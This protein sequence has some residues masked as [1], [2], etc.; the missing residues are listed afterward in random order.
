METWEK[1]LT[2]VLVLLVL[3]WFR[4]GIK[5]ALKESREAKTRDWQGV[6]LPIGFVVLVVILLL[7][8][9]R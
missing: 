7:V 1:I 5:Q 6:I 2:G 4:P 3:L 9:A 8:L